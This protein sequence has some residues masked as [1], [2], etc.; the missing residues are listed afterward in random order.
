MHNEDDMN[1]MMLVEADFKI[2]KELTNKINIL[3][4]K[5]EKLIVN[6]DEF[7][8]KMIIT[9]NP[10]SKKYE[11]IEN[12][13]SSDNTINVINI[14][15]DMKIQEL[16]DICK[17]NYLKKYS[18]MNKNNLIQYIIDNIDLNILQNINK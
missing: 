7:I 1:E 2:I 14:L 18:N 10:K 5:L 9:E 4:K 13:I 17:N 3:D 16:K 8:E 11:N 15:H 12:D 6:N